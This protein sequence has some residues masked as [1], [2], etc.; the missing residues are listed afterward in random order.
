MEILFRSPTHDGARWRDGAI[1]R[2]RQALH[3]LRRVVPRVQVRLDTVRGTPSGPD[4]CCRLLLD[5]P[6]GR[7]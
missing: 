6:D 7:G 1:G 2:L 4:K 3:R 5:L